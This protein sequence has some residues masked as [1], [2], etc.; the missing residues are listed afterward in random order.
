MIFVYQI[1]NLIKLMSFHET[2]IGGILKIEGNVVKYC[3]KDGGNCHPINVGKPVSMA[4]W[5]GST[6][7]IT[8]QDGSV[9]CYGTESGWT[10]M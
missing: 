2:Q 3:R 6:L 9:R 5:Q 8:C 4:Q 10:S 7:I 1:I